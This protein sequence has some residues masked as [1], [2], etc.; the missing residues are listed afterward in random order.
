MNDLG[1][2]LGQ[3][4]GGEDFIP[5]TRI[6]N[7]QNQTEHED[8]ATRD[9][10]SANHPQRRN[11][12]TDVPGLATAIRIRPLLTSAS[13]DRAAAF[14]MIDFLHRQ[15]MVGQGARGPRFRSDRTAHTFRSRPAQPRLMGPFVLAV[16]MILQRLSQGRPPIND[17]AIKPWSVA[18][19]SSGY[20]NA[21]CTNSHVRNTDCSAS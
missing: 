3:R 15:T 8:R 20:V 2:L 10:P 4:P 1:V 21:M 18:S 5:P 13:K 17:N 7:D 16:F 6:E 14:P 19:S 12:P 11:R 9:P